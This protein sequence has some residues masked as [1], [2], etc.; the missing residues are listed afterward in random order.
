MQCAAEPKRIAI[1][2]IGEL[3]SS[4]DASSR[5]TLIEFDNRGESVSLKVE[6]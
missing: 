3:K 2:P 4:W 1:E 6:L 5:T